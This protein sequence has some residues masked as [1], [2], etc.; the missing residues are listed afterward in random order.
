MSGNYNK[1]SKSTEL[2]MFAFI[3]LLFASGLNTLFA[4][5]VVLDELD[6]DTAL[7]FALE[8]NFAIR[9]AQ[10]RIAKQEHF[11]VQVRSVVL[12]QLGLNYNYSLID[13]NRLEDFGGSSFGSDQDWSINLELTQR[14]YA[15]GRG[16]TRFAEEKQR[17]KAAKFEMQAI[18]QEQMLKVRTNFYNIL[19]AREQI[20]VQ[21]QSLTLLEQQLKTVQDR[22]DAGS[23]PRFELIRAQVALANGR[24][25][26][27]RAK[28]DYRI[29]LKS[30]EVIVRYKASLIK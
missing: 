25:P 13:R 16:L 28:N 23:V 24:P 14:L 2:S 30:G 18:I 10:E 27:I 20:K 3:C 22:Y 12:P 11:I 8:N 7:Q 1:T 26:L 4:Q 19:L 21:T 17:L 6:L 29:T 9:Q 5:I 15:G